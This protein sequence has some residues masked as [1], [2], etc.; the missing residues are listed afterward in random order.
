MVGPYLAALGIVWKV[1]LAGKAS[2]GKWLPGVGVLW[3]LEKEHK[4]K[5]VGHPEKGQQLQRPSQPGPSFAS[6]A[7]A[8]HARR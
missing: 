3:A 6:L 8:M 4:H 2:G 1:A 7:G 5:E